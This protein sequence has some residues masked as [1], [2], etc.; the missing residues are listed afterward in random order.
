[1]LN[2]GNKTNTE[3]FLSC[4]LLISTRIDLRLSTIEKVF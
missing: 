1:M 3:Y 2:K 4:F